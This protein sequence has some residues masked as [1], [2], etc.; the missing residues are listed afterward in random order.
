MVL[1]SGSLVLPIIII[2][3]IIIVVVVSVTY[4]T[5]PVGSKGP[6]PRVFVAPQIA[7]RLSEPLLKR[8]ER[9]RILVPATAATHCLSWC[10]CVRCSRATTHSRESVQRLVFVFTARTLSSNLTGDTEVCL[11]FVLTRTGRRLADVHGSNT[12]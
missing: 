2:I 12:D 4:H 3:I 6:F 8:Y 9:P 5:R 1:L 10:R 7:T 11:R